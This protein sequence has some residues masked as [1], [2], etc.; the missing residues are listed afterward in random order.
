MASDL[1]T[2]DGSGTGI[3]KSKSNEVQNEEFAAATPGNMGPM[4][5]VLRL[6]HD[7]FRD[8]LVP[9]LSP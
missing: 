4:A 3:A 5:W 2:H 8:I 7:R 6:C 1:A 9:L